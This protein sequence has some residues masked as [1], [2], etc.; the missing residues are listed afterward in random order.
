MEATVIPFIYGYAESFSEGR[1]VVSFPSKIEGEGIPLIIDKSGTEIVKPGLYEEIFTYSE[2]L[3]EV[4]NDGISGYIDLD[5]NLAI[6][7]QFKLSDEGGFF[8]EGMAC[9]RKS[10]FRVL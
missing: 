2:G 3:A 10:R 7:L 5:G 4:A 8:S 6:P 1:A 9:V